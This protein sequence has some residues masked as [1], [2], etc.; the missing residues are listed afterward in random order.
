MDIVLH[1]SPLPKETFDSFLD[2]KENIDEFTY[3]QDYVI[4]KNFFDM[5]HI[6]FKCDKSQISIKQ[7]NLIYQKNTRSQL[8][9]CPFALYTQ[10]I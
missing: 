10:C 5:D 3:I 4:Y 2:M 6:D 9:K 8:I 7:N 1:M